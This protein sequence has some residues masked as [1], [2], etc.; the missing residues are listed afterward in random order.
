MIQAN[1][2]YITPPTNTP[3]DTTRRLFLA[4]A[5]FASVAGAG[6]LAAAANAGALPYRSASTLPR[7]RGRLR[8][9]DRSLRQTI[10][11]L[12]KATEALEQHNAARAEYDRS[13]GVGISVARSLNPGSFSQAPRM[14]TLGEDELRSSTRSASS[15]WPPRFNAGQPD[16][17]KPEHLHMQRTRGIAAQGAP[18]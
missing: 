2:V 17:F 10:G 3:V 15:P 5:A 9:T 12:G 18:V 16:L 1:C 6:S 11:R 13:G 7:T 14:P 8:S 4:V